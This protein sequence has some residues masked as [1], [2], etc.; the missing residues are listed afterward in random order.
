[1]ESK[2]WFGED[3]DP[4]YKLSKATKKTNPVE[5]RNTI[6]FYKGMM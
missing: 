3:G 4:D 6:E 5:W 2:P 1:M